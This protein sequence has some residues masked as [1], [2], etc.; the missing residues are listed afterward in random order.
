MFILPF[1][2]FMAEH[3]LVSPPLLSVCF[4]HLNQVTY[5]VVFILNFT[6]SANYVV[7]TVVKSAVS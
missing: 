4:I 1:F 2:S 7:L 3:C 5:I 6:L